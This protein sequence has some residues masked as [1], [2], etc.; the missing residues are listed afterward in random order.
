MADEA[1]PRPWHYKPYIGPYIFDAEC[2]TAI[3]HL[4]NG[5]EAK[6]PLDA[7]ARLIVTAVNNFGPL[8]E[9]LMALAEHCR[10][11]E[12]QNPDY[13]TQEGPRLS[14]PLDRAYALLAD[15]QEASSP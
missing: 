10:G 15:V 5:P 1:T 9:A 7:N 8:V 11:M 13:H 12:S 4:Y 14:Y 6:I 2:M 3:L